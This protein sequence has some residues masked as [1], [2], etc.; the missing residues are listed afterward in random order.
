LEKLGRRKGVAAHELKN[1]QLEALPVRAA[2]RND[3][4][5]ADEKRRFIILKRGLL[6]LRS[7]AWRLAKA[8]QPG[9]IVCSEGADR[10]S[11]AA[12]RVEEWRI[13]EWH[14]PTEAPY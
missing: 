13:E 3:R 8:F 10:R 5:S 7:V 11:V 9:L 12:W 1:I 14:S 2:R 6:T 4:L